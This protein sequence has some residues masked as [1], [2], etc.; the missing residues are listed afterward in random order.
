MEHKAT[1][2]E[3]DALS[4]IVTLKDMGSPKG[5]GVIATMNLEKGEFVGVMA[6][7][8][9]REEAH[10][11]MVQT[12]KITGRYAMETRDQN[13]ETYVVEPEAPHRGKPSRRFRSSMALFM[14]EPGPAEQLNVAWAFNTAYDPERVECYTMKQVA[15]GEE[16]LVHYGDSY[17]RTYEKPR[18]APPSPWTRGKMTHEFS[19]LQ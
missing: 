19:H 12:G 16:L 5:L 4:K 6:G 11:F 8:V 1:K 17:G 14:N 18:E 15:A 13:L 2:A 9:M 10:N 7:C 3:R